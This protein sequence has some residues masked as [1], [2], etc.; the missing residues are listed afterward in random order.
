MLPIA[1]TVTSPEVASR[2]TPEI[3]AETV[4]PVVAMA[5]RLPIVSSPT[6]KF[7]RAIALD[8]ETVF[9]LTFKESAETLPAP[10]I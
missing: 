6:V 4:S 8:S 9:A 5:D 3:V 10:E 1:T 7:L 2:S